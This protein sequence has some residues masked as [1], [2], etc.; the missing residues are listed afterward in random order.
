[1]S[2]ARNDRPGYL[3]VLAAVEQGIID[4]LL[5]D[6]LS[7]LSRDHSQ[8]LA[9]YSAGGL[10]YG[11]RSV[12][13][14]KGH[15]RVI[16]EDQARWVRYAFERYAAGVSPRAIAA[17]L[18]ARSAPSPRGGPWRHTALYPDA[19]GVG[20]LGNPIYNGRQVWN[21][22]VWVKDPETG[23]RRRLM[24]PKS[25]WVVVET[26]ELKIIDNELWAACEGRARSKKRES[27]EKLRQGRRPGGGQAKYLF[28][29]LLRCGVCGGAFVIVDRD[30]YG[31]AARKDGG[32]H[33]CSNSLKVRR[34]TVEQVLLAGVKNALL[35]EDGFRRFESECREIMK[36][37]RPDPELA[38]RKLSR[39]RQERDNI[40]AAL[41][42][43]IITPTVKATLEETEERVREAEEELRSIARFEP[44]QMLPR[45]REIYRDLVTRLDSVEDV[46]VARE[47]LRELIGEVTLTPENGALTAEIQ[48]AGLAGALQIALVAGEGFEPSTF[49]L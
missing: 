23:R 10:P 11:Y 29:G 6:D 33:A 30:H 5:L 28:S 24:R 12:S 25:E 39:A 8:A 21:R 16:V 43:G 4:V 7:R 14:G 20:I 38:R 18:N 3:A 31:C 27:A 48:S 34:A 15:K 9:G 19:K 44:S 2:G 41:K 47:A 35:N 46:S 42:A 49:G 37:M 22:T 32:E 40:I 13:D 36:S 26:P 45:A 1:M 17:E